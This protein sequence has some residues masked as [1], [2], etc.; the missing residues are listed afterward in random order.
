MFISKHLKV[1]LLDRD[2]TF[3]LGLG[4]LAALQGK[5]IPR[6]QRTVLAVSRQE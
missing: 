2:S 3:D 6:A 1:T 4:K 5:R